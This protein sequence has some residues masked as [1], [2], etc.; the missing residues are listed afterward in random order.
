MI[1][2]VAIRLDMSFDQRDAGYFLKPLF[3]G[4]DVF[5]LNLQEKH[6]VV[7]NPV[8]PVSV[9]ARYGPFT[10]QQQVPAS[11]LRDSLG[12]QSQLLG[13]MLVGS[14]EVTAHV[15]ARTLVRDRPILQVLFH[16]DHASVERR[17]SSKIRGEGFSNN[18]SNAQWCMQV[19]V[20]R[21]PLQE[22][23]S[24]CVLGDDVCLAD[25]TLPTAWWDS[26]ITGGDSPRN[27]D[28]YYSAFRADKNSRC[29]EANAGSS[30]WIRRYVATVT[31]THGQVTYQELKEDHHILVY[32]PQAS[33]YP[34]S[35]FRVPIKLQAESDLQVFAVRWVKLTLSLYFIYLE[36]SFFYLLN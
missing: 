29:S 33:F 21:S 20:V 7:T 14:L 6:F 36:L 27:V 28:V 16:G 34:G 19:H 4:N 10:V 23:S 13:N 9:D 30:E 12:N 25:V 24:V 11:L 1:S 32:V 8:G 17:S 26:T 3:R 2:G 22:L 18:S 5:S 35:R 31:L 15:V